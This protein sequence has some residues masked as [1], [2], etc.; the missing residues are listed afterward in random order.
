LA[1]ESKTVR[2]ITFLWA[3]IAI[4]QDVD[5]TRYGRTPAET[6]YSPLAQIDAG[7]VARL[8]LAWSYQ[9]GR[10]GGIQEATPLVAN[11]TLY[12]ITNWSVVFALDAATGREKWRWDPEV[13]QEFVR[14]KICCGVVNRGVALFEDL[15]IAPSIDGRLF[16]LDAAT[17]RPRWEARV[18][19]PQDNYTITMAPR[20]V[21]D[22]VIIGVSGAE[23]PT[24]GFFDAYEARTGRRR[25]R[26]YTVPGNPSEPFENP[27][28]RTAAAT[29]S[30]DYWKLN[31]GGSVWDGMAYD[32]EANLL[33]VGT[34][35]GGPWPE[36]LR[37]SQGLDN[38]YLCSILA[39]NPD[40]GRLKWHFQMVPGDSW[41]FDGVQQMILADLTWN[42]RR[43][44]V[45]MQANKNG[46]FYVLDRITGQFLSGVPFARVNWTSGLD[47]RT[48]RPYIQPA[49]K[50]GHALVEIAP[51]T[52]G[53]HNW[54]PMA[55]H[56]GTGLVYIP[57]ALDTS[58]TFG[59][60]TDFVFHEGQN[61]RG[62]RRGPPPP[63]GGRGADL[64]AQV[65][66]PPSIGPQVAPGQSNVLLAWDPVAQQARWTRPGGGSVGGG[67]LATAGNLVFQV[68]PD[69]RLV[70]YTAD[71]GEKVLDIDTGLRGGMGPPMTYMVNGKQYVALMGGL[72]IVVGPNVPPGTPAPQPTPQTVFPQLLAYAL[73]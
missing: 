38:L 26:F 9:A 16:G 17:G 22:K 40:T 41:D 33:Y 32:P 13:A 29:W 2:R 4:A 28:L 67:A 36:A 61:N 31:G 53:A 54:P 66:P 18:A 50:Y 14:S 39:V 10:G 30:G 63:E 1:V 68:I 7:N 60:D 15:V 72:G 45:L 23:Y 35:N 44:K 42:G 11:G 56:P 69:G 55:Y 43:R 47:P 73:E 24:R 21:K 3:V 20:I 70:A 52:A 59:L 34:G 6:R 71:R 19:Y 65:P 64:P 48:G 62:I 12:S 49:A 51:G 37:G 57:A 25:W 8:R 5:W 58:S 46:I 27:A